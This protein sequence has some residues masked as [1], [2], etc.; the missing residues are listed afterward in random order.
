M[1][2]NP[3]KC[4][5]EVRAHIFVPGMSTCLIENCRCEKFFRIPYKT[6]D[7]EDTPE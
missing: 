3:C 6:E 7:E 4:G 5:H 1:N 2:P